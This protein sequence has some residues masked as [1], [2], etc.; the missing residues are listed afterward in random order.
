MRGKEIAD[1]LEMTVCVAVDACSQG[2][3]VDLRISKLR[4]ILWGLRVLS[5]DR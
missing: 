1:L 3:L 4:R 2:G 5:V